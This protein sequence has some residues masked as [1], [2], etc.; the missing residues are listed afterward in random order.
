MMRYHLRASVLVT[1]AALSLCDSSMSQVNFGMWDPYVQ[2]PDL[3]LSQA[4]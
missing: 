4:F 2:D 1:A 3:H